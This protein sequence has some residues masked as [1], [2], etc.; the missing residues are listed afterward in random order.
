[1]FVRLKSLALL[2]ALTLPLPLAA[3]Q[4]DKEAQCRL[5]GELMGTIQKARLDGVRKAQLQEAV[6]EAR[7]DFSPAILATVPQLGNYVYDF[8]KRDLRKINLAE[9][10]RVQCLQNW[11]QIQQLRKSV[12]N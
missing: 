3:Q 6:A 8:R 4:V 7:P 5:Q 1:M 9:S 12:T 11:D 10:T 2:C